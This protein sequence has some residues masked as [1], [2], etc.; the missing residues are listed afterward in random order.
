MPHD[1]EIFTAEVATTAL[2]CGDARGRHEGQPRAASIAADVNQRRQFH[3]LPT[4]ARCRASR[5]KPT[6]SRLVGSK[7]ALT[8]VPVAL[9]I[10]AIAK[11]MAAIMASM[12]GPSN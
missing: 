11:R 8:A 3:P 5:A 6:S 1:A 9:I 2:T 10:K 4:P 7:M 12:A